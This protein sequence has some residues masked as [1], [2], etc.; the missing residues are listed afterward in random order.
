V[1][2]KWNPWSVVAE[3]FRVAATR[4]ALLQ[5]SGRGK[6]TVVTSAVKGEGKSVVAA[7]LAYTLARDIGKSTLLIDGDLKCPSV[8]H[9]WGMSQSP[10]LKDVLGGSQ[11]LES[12]LRQEGELPLWI[13]PS[14]SERGRAG[15]D[16]SRIRH[17]AEILNELKE[18]YDHVIIDGPP[19]LPLADMQVMAGMTDTIAFVIRAGLTP[20][21]AVENALR[22]L[23]DTTKTYIILNEL[24]TRGMPYYMQ[25]GYEYFS[26]T[27][28]T[29]V[30]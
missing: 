4:L 28:E 6:V 26:E 18:K 12:C 15:D 21:S 22:T 30:Q 8:H 29:G 27:R 2:G 5:S 23:G 24:E 19:V 13:L 9:Y 11:S 14:G 20:R 3:Q 10:G 16:L 7:N 17:I 1:I 25:E